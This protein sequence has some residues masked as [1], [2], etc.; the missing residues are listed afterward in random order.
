MTREHGVERLLR[1]RD[2][3]LVASAAGFLVWQGGWLATDLLPRGM[4]MSA[5]IAGTVAGAVI[6]AAATVALAL[7]YRRVRKARAGAE[8][9]DELARHRQDR[10]FLVGYWVVAAAI[11]GLLGLSGFVEIEDAVLLRFLVIL[12]VV[13]PLTAFLW[14]DRDTGSNGTEEEA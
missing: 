3:V 14:I 2:R 1:M 6:W 8:L 13:T 5:A 11:A 9:N 4:L 10:A 7:Y 12:A